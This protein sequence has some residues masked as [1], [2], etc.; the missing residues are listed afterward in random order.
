VLSTAQ[1]ADIKRLAIE[2]NEADTLAGLI[3]RHC[4]DPAVLAR[5]VSVLRVTTEE[6]VVDVQAS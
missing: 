5:V 6:V 3:P 1:A 2:A 4:D